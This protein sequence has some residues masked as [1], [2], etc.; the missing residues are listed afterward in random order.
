LAAADLARADG[1]RTGVTC[2]VA[3][4]RF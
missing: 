1:E 4:V 3:R 2:R